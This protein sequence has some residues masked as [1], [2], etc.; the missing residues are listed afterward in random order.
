MLELE[1]EVRRLSVYVSK[2]EQEKTSLQQHLRSEEY[3]RA[4]EVMA[5]HQ[6]QQEANVLLQKQVRLWALMHTY[7]ALGGAG[8]FNLYTRTC[9][10]RHR[11]TYIVF[12]ARTRYV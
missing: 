4:T 1:Q 8:L 7:I 3:S 11:F 10:S 5:F 9:L 2:L 6:Q 12:N